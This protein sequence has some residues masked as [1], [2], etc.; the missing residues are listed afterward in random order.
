MPAAAPAPV[1]L[2][3]GQGGY[4]PGVLSPE[5]ARQ[6]AGTLRRVA[7][8]SAAVGGAD[9]VDLLTDPGAPS[10]ADLVATAPERLHLAIFSTEIVA[11]ELCAERFGPP[12][13]LAGHS[14]GEFAALTVAG[15]L[16]LEGGVACVTARDRALIETAPPAGGMTVLRTGR[17][18]AQH[19]LGAVHDWRL[20]LAVENGP[21]QSVVSGPHDG[22]DHL[23]RVSAALG[24][25]AHRLTVPYPFHNRLLAAAA[26]RFAEL[27]RDVPVRA[28][29]TPVHSAVLGRRVTDDDDVREVLA[30]HLVQPVGFLTALHALRA[31]GFDWFVECGANAI[32]T[33]I[34]R[35]ALPGVRTDAPWSGRAAP[36]PA[37]A[38]AAPTPAPAPAPEPAPAATSAPDATALLATLRGMYAEAVGYPVEVF[39]PDVELEADLGIDSLRQ[40]AL[41]QRAHR[42]LGLEAPAGLRITD[43]VTLEHVADLLTAQQVPA[44]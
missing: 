23:E 38:T 34:V 6:T 25:D 12:A 40:T 4:R 20:A 9:V 31:E 19:V 30:A 14:F 37:P 3:P 16:D 17:T 41:L 10:L 26:D 42:E 8:A 13:L 36:A 11:A 29:R 44:R 15:A 24:V 39:E 43:Y 33:G 21:E 2:L 32:L 35:A 27:V 7:A 28:P 18:R 22:L 1:L 5:E